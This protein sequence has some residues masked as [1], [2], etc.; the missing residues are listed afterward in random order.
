MVIAS[1]SILLTSRASD[2]QPTWRKEGVS[3]DDSLTALSQCKYEIRPEQHLMRKTKS[4]P[5]VAGPRVSL[6]ESRQ[7]FVIG[8]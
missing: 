7:D 2:P 6:E 4:S 5:I 1:M 3:H 8:Y